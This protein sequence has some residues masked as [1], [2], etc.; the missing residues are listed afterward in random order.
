MPPPPRTVLEELFTDPRRRN[1]CV[2]LLAGRLREDALASGD[3]AADVGRGRARHRSAASDRR[4]RFRRVLPLEGDD[5]VGSGDRHRLRA[6]RLGAGLAD[7]PPEDPA[8]ALARASAS[9]TPTSERYT[10]W[11]R[12][13]TAK[14]RLCPGDRPAF[15]CVFP[16]PVVS[17]Y[18][19][20]PFAFVPFSAVSSSFA[21][22]TTE[23]SAR[24]RTADSA[25][26]LTGVFAT[27][28][29]AAGRR[30]GR[31]RGITIAADRQ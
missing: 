21:P 10:H 2:C 12:L 22:P 23:R 7:R 14:E 6:N 8:A 9:A 24:W 25:S 5:G 19:R 20:W 27:S 4:R 13:Q 16:Q 11:T 31:S 29:S 15:H 1:P 28:P 26:V 30:Y 18:A 17:R 3:D